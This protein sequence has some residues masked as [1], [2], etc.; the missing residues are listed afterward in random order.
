ME[1]P[2]LRLRKLAVNKEATC[3]VASGPEEIADH[4][5][6]WFSA[7]ETHPN[8]PQLLQSTSTQ[9]PPPESLDLCPQ[10]LLSDQATQP[11][12]KTTDLRV[13]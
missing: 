6:Q 1:D 2:R 5:E 13:R 10:G 11:S 4:L 8:Y 7:P 12:W 3:T 9:P